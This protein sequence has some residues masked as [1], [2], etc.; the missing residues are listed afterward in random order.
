MWGNNRKCNTEV[1]Q[2]SAALN[3]VGKG[4]NVILVIYVYT[5]SVY[6]W[7]VAVEK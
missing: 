1:A 5:V 7:Q 4:N 2:S 6:C 3:S